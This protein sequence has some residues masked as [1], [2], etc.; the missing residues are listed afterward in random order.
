MANEW[1]HVHYGSRAVGGAG[2]ILVEATAVNPEGRISP[3]DLGL[4]NDQQILPMRQMTDF[5]QQNGVVPGI[6]IGHAGAK[7]SHAP[8]WEGSGYLDE[9]NG[10]WVPRAPSAVPAYEGM[11]M[12]QELTPDEIRSVVNDFAMAAA[13]ARKAGFRVI[14]IHAAHG[15]LIHEFLSPLVNK[16]K[17]KYGGSFENR[18]RFLQEIITAV[19]QEWPPELPLLCRLSV[20]D[21]KETEDSWT[22]ADSIRLAIE[23][24]QMGVDMLDCSSAGLSQAPK[25]KVGSGFQTIF[26]EKI[27]KQVKIPTAAVGFISS[28]Q[29]A[30]HVICTGQADMALLGRR[31]LNDPY[32][33]LHAAK[34][35]GTEIEWPKQYS[36][37]F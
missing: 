18:I 4:W 8:L 5:M 22:L 30:D 21:W 34:I 2:L 35:L 27:R 36:R 33:P 29:Q 11:P 17:D 14:E 15:Y 26:A 10:G 25:D 12:P 1:H 9:N 6:Q 24:K 23:L 16:R 20:T 19:Q 7:A 3:Y 28:P 31:Y 32:W 13:R 37:Q